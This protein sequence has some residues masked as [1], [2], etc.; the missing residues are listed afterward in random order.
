M[1]LVPNG[2]PCA[3][4]WPGVA[5]RCADRSG[6]NLLGLEGPQNLEGGQFTAIGRIS[7]WCC[8]SVR[9]SYWAAVV[10]IPERCAFRFLKEH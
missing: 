5:R 4:K 9:C 8:L 7:C 10:A 3:E 1:D 6:W 2:S